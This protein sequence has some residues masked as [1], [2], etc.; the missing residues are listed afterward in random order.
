[1]IGRVNKLITL[2]LTRRE[3]KLCLTEPDLFNK[4]IKFNDPYLFIRIVFVTDN[5]IVSNFVS[6]NF[7]WL[8]FDSLESEFGILGCNRNCNLNRNEDLNF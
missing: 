1:M 8:E 4:C 5:R 7:R 3:K 2:I 6:S